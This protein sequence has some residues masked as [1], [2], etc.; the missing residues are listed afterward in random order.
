MRRKNWK[1]LM[2]G[3]LGAKL[4]MGYFVVGMMFVTVGFF[5]IWGFS[6]NSIILVIV[7]SVLLTMLLGL[8]VIR[9]ILRPIHQLHSATEEVKKGNFK[10][11]V[12]INTGDELADL[13]NMFNKMA[14]ALGR[15]DEERKQVDKAKTE[16]ISITSHE[17][18]SPMTP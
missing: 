14:E 5:S 7:I 11:R 17:L 15:M 12:E 4:L 1:D 10:E 18:R 2:F 8:T 13:G 6:R 9:A 16:F 3:S